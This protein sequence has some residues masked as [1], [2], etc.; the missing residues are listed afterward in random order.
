MGKYLHLHEVPRIGK[1]RETK[2]ITEVTRGQK[3]GNRMGNYCFMGTEFLFGMIKKSSAYR[4][5]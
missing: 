1:F 4:Y 2:T 5:W 3:G